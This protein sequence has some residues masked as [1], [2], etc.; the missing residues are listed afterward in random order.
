MR[1]AIV[2]QASGVVAIVTLKRRAEFQRVRGG[3]RYSA[4]AFLLEC[5][6]RPE[7]Q[8]FG[9]DPRFG[10][11]ITK[12]IG[13]AV[14]RNRIRRRLRGA[15]AGMVQRSARPGFDYVIVARAPAF[16]CP[17]ADLVA[18]LETAFARTAKAGARS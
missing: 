4:P 10:F 13:N 15:I 12:K 18:D 5:K 6:A 7:G 17:F 14:V 1:P 9:Q 2:G 8:N 3:A 11:T 16:D